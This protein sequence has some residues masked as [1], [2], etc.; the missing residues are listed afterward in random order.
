MIELH[1]F[2]T[3]NGWKVSIALE[4]L[5]LEYETH[6]VNIS[7]GE[8]FEPS[9]LEISPNNRVPAIVDRAPVGGGDP[10]SIFESGAILLYL[11]EKTGRLMPGDFRSRIAATEWLMWQMG[12][13]GP[14]CGQAGHF[15]NYAP[16][17]IDYALER[18]SN[19][20]SRLYGVLDKR[21]EGRDYIADEYSMADIACWPW[22][23]LHGHHN[24][25]PADFP[26]VQRW[27]A[28]IG[29][30]DAVKRGTGVGLEA[31]QGRQPIDDEA[32]KHLFGRR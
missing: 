11:A 8:Q 27:H 15:I 28:T 5:G 26:N 29:E 10:I 22:I 32:K 18:Y 3:P 12:G 9:F 17:K 24:I 13:L 19:E 21:L 14:M 25:D 31:V 1:T 30:R 23:A 2:P 7:R 20:A 4:E 16:E 6:L